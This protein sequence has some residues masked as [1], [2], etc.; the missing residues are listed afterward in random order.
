[1]PFIGSLEVADPPDAW[2]DLGFTIADGRSQVGTVVHELVGGPGKGVLS[3]T[4]D[5][6]DLAGDLDGVPTAVGNG[7]AGPAPD[8]PNGSLY[9]D[10]LVAMTPNLERTIKAF[11]AAG[12][13][14]R[15]RRD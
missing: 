1:M 9:I 7:P 2:A 11:E 15:R 8:H 6:A 10:H 4:L 5:G 12:I 3:W 14:C 13:L